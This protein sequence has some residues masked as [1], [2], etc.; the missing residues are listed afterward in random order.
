MMPRK[1]LLI[2]SLAAT[3]AAHNQLFFA[4]DPEQSLV[5]DQVPLPPQQDV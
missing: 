5:V 1:S 2:S 3:T 4:I